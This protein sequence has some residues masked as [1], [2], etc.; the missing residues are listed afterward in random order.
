M[1]AADANLT[2]FEMIDF[3]YKFEMAQR[4]GIHVHELDTYEK[5]HRV[6][7]EDAKRTVLNDTFLQRMLWLEYKLALANEIGIHPID[8]DMYQKESCDH[9]ANARSFVCKYKI[10]DACKQY[11]R[12]M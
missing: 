4:I 2:L 11:L 8:L 3:D 9:F 6:H 1:T 10:S 7:F 12:R 5:E